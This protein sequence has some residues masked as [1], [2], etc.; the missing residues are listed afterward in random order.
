MGGSH[1]GNSLGTGRWLRFVDYVCWI[2]GNRRNCFELEDSSAATYR[3][4]LNRCAV[5]LDKRGLIGI[6]SG[7]NRICIAEGN[8]IMQ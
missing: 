4:C 3:L 6:Q 8:L 5:S 2:I 7:F 1:W